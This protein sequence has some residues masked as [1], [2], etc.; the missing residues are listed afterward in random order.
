MFLRTGAEGAGAGFFYYFS[1]VS[2]ISDANLADS[3]LFFAIWSPEIFIYGLI[4]IVLARCSGFA[5]LIVFDA[6]LANISSYS[7]I[8]SINC[9]SWLFLSS[10]C[11][12]RKLS[13]IILFSDFKVNAGM[14]KEMFLSWASW[15]LNMI[16]CF[17]LFL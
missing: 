8:F 16:I 9:Y 11:G 15:G 3:D 7:I 12:F 4:F 2:L 1:S 10:S 14:K 6:W 5:F 13:K 17:V